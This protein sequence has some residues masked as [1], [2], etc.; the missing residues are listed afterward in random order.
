MMQIRIVNTVTVMLNEMLQVFI[1]CGSCLENPGTD[2]GV[3]VRIA[4]AFG[5]T[6]ATMAQ[7][8]GHVSGCH[9]NPA[10]T[11]GLLF[12]RKIGIIKALLYVTAQVLGAL[13][14]SGLLKVKRKVFPLV[15]IRHRTMRSSMRILCPVI[16]T[17]DRLG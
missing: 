15:R 2:G 10:V 8:L 3:T 17:A 16:P 1:G 5:V 13:V 4:L 11:A 12:G 9:V 14:G 7:G 6:V